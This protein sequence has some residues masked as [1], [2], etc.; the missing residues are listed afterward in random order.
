[1]DPLKHSLSFRS[2]SF[3]S[4]SLRSATGA[5]LLI[6]AVLVG[7][8]CDTVPGTRDLSDAPP[9]VS[10]LEF[11]PRII[12]LATV[13]PADIDDGNLP[14]T[15]SI[16]VD[17]DGGATGDISAVNY[18]VR[19][20]LR[21]SIPIASGTLEATSG[22]TFSASATLT[23]PVGQ[24]GNYT[25]VV[26]AADGLGQL[27]NQAV[28]NL[29]LDASNAPGSPPVIESVESSPE[30]ITPPAV[31]IIVANVT[32]PDGVANLLRVE[33][34]TPNGQTFNMY[35]DGETLGDQVAGDGRFTAAFDVPVGVPAGVQV[36]ELQAFDRNGNESA[37]VEKP[38][39]IQ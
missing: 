28:G 12:D 25:V 2:A 11:S 24:P 30:P 16:S 15:L 22:N 17:V 7:V 38:V 18:V 20:P 6:I 8:G 19:P 39:T 34:K 23:L 3:S 5:T 31:L 32:D 35:D 37:V 21:S 27:S 9:R 33:I 29:L 4:A 26:Y 13:N 36:F 1:M 14:V 10:T